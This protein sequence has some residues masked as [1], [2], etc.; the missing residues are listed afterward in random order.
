MQRAFK[1]NVIIKILKLIKSFDN[2]PPFGNFAEGLF[3][4]FMEKKDFTNLLS[5]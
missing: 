3:S 1:K 2:N 5:Y 4:F